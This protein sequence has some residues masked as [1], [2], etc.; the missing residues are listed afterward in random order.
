MLFELEFEQEE[1]GRWLAE[2]PALPGV[3]CYGVT[4][5]DAGNKVLAL[6]MRWVADK[7]ENG[8]FVPGMHS[9]SFDV[10]QYGPVAVC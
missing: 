6:A 3:M 5:Q 4:R 9:I 2:I 7:L 8:E 1:D 10:P